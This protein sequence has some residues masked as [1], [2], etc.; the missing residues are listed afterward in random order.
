MVAGEDGGLLVD[1][2]DA[3][4]PGAVAVFELVAGAEV[5]DAGHVGL[6]HVDPLLLVADLVPR[7][8]DVGLGDR[9][10]LVFGDLF[11]V[12]RVQPLLRAHQILGCVNGARLTA[13][14]TRTGPAYLLTGLHRLHYL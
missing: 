2:G 11:G 5:A 9:P 8:I 1:G 6:Q 13:P 14:L 3:L 12:G 7:F 10:H 4:A